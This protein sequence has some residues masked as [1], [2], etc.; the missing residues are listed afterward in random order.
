MKSL[1]TIVLLLFARIVQGQNDSSE[2]VNSNSKIE[3]KS[4]VGKQIRSRPH[5]EENLRLI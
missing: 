5:L 2:F 3:S 4:V 1:I